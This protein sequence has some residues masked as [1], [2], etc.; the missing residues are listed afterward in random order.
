MAIPY[1][2]VLFVE[3]ASPDAVLRGR[4]SAD[5]LDPVLHP[6]QLVK[7]Y[8]SVRSASSAKGTPGV[9]LES[10]QI[11]SLLNYLEH[12]NEVREALETALAAD[13][14][15]WLGDADVLQ[16]REIWKHAEVQYLLLEQR[17]LQTVEGLAPLADRVFPGLDRKEMEQIVAMSDS[18]ATRATF[19][20][21]IAVA[22]DEEHQ[23]R[24]ATFRDGN[25]VR[26]D[27]EGG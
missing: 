10:F 13:R 19:T 2:L 27:V 15:G 25:F 6:K 7:V 11:D 20:V 14:L 17:T 8:F 9:E 1:N 16:P 4:V 12:Q 26:L 24:T 3:P 22:W 21:G 23:V 18:P 5:R